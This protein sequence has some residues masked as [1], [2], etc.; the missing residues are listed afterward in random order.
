MDKE[1]RKT[2][3]ALARS[4]SIF[5]AYIDRP[6]EDV[7]R[8]AKKHMSRCKNGCSVRGA[9]GNEAFDFELSC[10]VGSAFYDVIAEQM[11]RE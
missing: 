3:I 11:N 8:R 4:R 9:E 7:F 5:K 1:K 10:V 6:I 2:E